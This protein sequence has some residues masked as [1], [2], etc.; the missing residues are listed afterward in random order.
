MQHFYQQTILCL[1]S[2]FFRNCRLAVLWQA[3]KAHNTLLF[4]VQCV[5]NS[6]ISVTLFLKGFCATGT[7]LSVNGICWHEILIITAMSAD[8]VQKTWCKRRKHRISKSKH[9]F[10]IQGPRFFSLFLFINCFSGI[11]F[12]TLY[13]SHS[14]LCIKKKHVKSLAK[15][16]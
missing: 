6:L 16:L 8:L 10:A 14:N 3:A 15:Y 13:S 7:K 5:F 1:S 12:Q 9:I 4:S 11:V 2:S